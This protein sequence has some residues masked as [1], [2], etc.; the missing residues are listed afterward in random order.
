MISVYYFRGEYFC[1]LTEGTWSSVQINIFM[2]E[3]VTGP[4]HKEFIKNIFCI[5][6]SKFFQNRLV[7]SYFEV[8]SGGRRRRRVTNR[9]RLL[10]PILKVC[11]WRRCQP[12]TIR[13]RRRRQFRPID[14]RPPMP[15]DGH[16]MGRPP[17]PKRSG[18]GAVRIAAAA[19]PYCP[20]S[21]TRV[22]GGQISG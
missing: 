21:A 4:N 10:I 9:Q 20:S 8:R 13:R 18:E 11:K 7:P 6:F 1:Q 19:R 12:F 17:P 16:G 2:R 15:V 3:G 5:S 14:R 22:Q